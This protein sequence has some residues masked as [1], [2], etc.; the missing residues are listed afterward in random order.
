MTNGDFDNFREDED[1]SKRSGKDEKKDTKQGKDRKTT[2]RIRRYTRPN[3]VDSINTLMA[4][5]WPKKTEKTWK[6]KVSPRQNPP[7]KETGV[8]TLTE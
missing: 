8:K 2:E 4:E 7:N 3:R 1:E 6:E 5:N